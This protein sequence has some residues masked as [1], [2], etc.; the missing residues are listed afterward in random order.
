MILGFSTIAKANETITFKVN[1]KAACKTQIEALVMSVQG[2][3]SAVWNAT[4]KKI[5]IVF[6]S[7]VLDR[8]G[9]YVILAEG[10]YDS[11]VEN[12]NHIYN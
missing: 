3:K 10:G 8:D 7:T 9:F 11:Y 12:L 6:N 1:G 4:T 5:T 2:V